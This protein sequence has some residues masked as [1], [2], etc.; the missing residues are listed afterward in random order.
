[1]N[2]NYVDCNDIGAGYLDVR[3]SCPMFQVLNHAYNDATHTVYP[4][5]LPLSSSLNRSPLM[6]Q[7]TRF[8]CGGIAV[9]LCISHQ[10]TDGCI[11][12][13]FFMIGQLQPDC[14]IS[15]HLFSLMQIVSSQ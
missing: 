1:M 10:I 2:N 9:S 6:V 3:V 7:L 5:D 15:D 11:H 8:D 13:S 12:V 14:W 4:Q